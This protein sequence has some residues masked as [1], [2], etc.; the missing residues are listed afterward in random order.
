MKRL[1]HIFTESPW[2]YTC[3]I[4]CS[5]I[6]YKVAHFSAISWDDPELVFNNKDVVHGQLIEFW[7]TSYQGMYMPLTMHLYR[8]Q[9]LV[10]QNWAGGYHLTSWS[11]HVLNAFLIYNIFNRFDTLKHYRGLLMFVFAIHPLQFENAIWIGEMK[12]LLATSFLLSAIL[13]I[14]TFYKNKSKTSLA[15]SILLVACSFLS[16][17]IAITLP[18]LLLLVL[19]LST[20]KDLKW[21]ILIFSLTLLSI[22]FSIITYRLQVYDHFIN[23]SHIQIWWSTIGHS[24][25][26][27][28]HYLLQFFWPFSLSI[29]YPYPQLT[30]PMVITGICCWLLLLSL[31]VFLKIKQKNMLLMGIGVF[32]IPLLPVLQ[33]I[34]FGEALYADRYMYISVLGICIICIELLKAFKPVTYVVF[35]M[36]GLISTLGALNYLPHWK[37]ETALYEYALQFDTDSYVLLNSLGVEYTRQGESKKA[38]V[39]FTKAQRNNPKNY[40]AY[41]N[42]GLLYLKLQNATI[43]I[44]HF[45]RSLTLYPYAKAYTA[46]GS[47]YLQLGDWPK[48]IS[49]FKQALKLDSTQHKAWILLADC[50]QQFNLLPQAITQYNKAIKLYPFDAESFFKRGICYGKQNQLQNALL[51]FNSAIR[52]NPN[53]GAYFYWIGI[54]KIALKHDP[55]ADF[56]QAMDLNYQAAITLHLKYCK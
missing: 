40:K 33:F 18:I 54:T 30:I 14:I 45:N 22:V 3:L 16:K 7:V 42:C 6:A 10:F 27:I 34:P 36:I 56:K 29:L 37:T 17:P 55:C 12:T 32:I 28:L 20:F 11:L 44:D 2:I 38:L 31:L 1:I 19:P 26:A 43:A 23:S 25:W 39:C 46:R 21:K 47:A 48:A 8:I 51:D 49:D 50:S 4:L 9:Y 15:I 35:F 13:Q 24:G 52:L 53:N 5:I 41:Y